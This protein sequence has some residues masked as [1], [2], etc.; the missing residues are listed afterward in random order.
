MDLSGK[1]TGQFQDRNDYMMYPSPVASR[2]PLPSGEGSL[3][4][5]R[6]RANESAAND[7]LFRIYGD[8]VTRL[9]HWMLSDPSD[10][11]RVVHETFQKVSC[12]IQSFSHDSSLRIWIFRIALSKIQ[13][14]TCWWKRQTR[15][16]AD[17]ELM[18]KEIVV[19]VG[20]QELSHGNRL[21]LVLRD[22]EGL[23]YAEISEVL[24]V[25]MRSVKSRLIRARGQMMTSIIRQQKSDSA[26][27]VN[28][29][30]FL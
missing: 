21:I 17:S 13:L 20:L 16:R 18:P 2:H 6:L 8:G 10:R 14:R 1:A 19:R 9:A 29:T 4:V 23:S 15:I 28:Q 30:T 5:E 12:S 11:S 7:E 25:S 24:G 26:L 27:L 3:L 22:I